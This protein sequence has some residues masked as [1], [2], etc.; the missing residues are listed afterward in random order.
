MC[1]FVKDVLDLHPLVDIDQD[2]VQEE[3]AAQEEAVAVTH[4]ADHDQGNILLVASNLS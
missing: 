2:H 1:N 3:M 4:T